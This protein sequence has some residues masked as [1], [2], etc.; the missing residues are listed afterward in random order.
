MPF[1]R[2]L[3]LKEGK[4]LARSHPARGTL[5]LVSWLPDAIG[6][7]REEPMRLQRIP[8]QRQSLQRTFGLIERIFSLICAHSFFQSLPQMMVP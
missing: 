7:S 2:K 6:G 3:Q 8:P 1:T 5:H 4:A